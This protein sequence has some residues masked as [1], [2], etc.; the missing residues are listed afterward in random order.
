MAPNS[1][2]AGINLMTGEITADVRDTHKSSGGTTQSL[3]R[4]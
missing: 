3:K 1:L 4:F 2:L